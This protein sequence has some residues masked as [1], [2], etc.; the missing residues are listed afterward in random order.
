M[1]IPA[2]IL[3]ALLAG[4]I[5]IAINILLL[6]LCDAAGIVTARGGLQR[7][8]RMWMG[9]PLTQIGVADLWAAAG[10]PGP[11]TALFRNGFK[12][13]VGL[14]MAVFYALVFEPLVARL[15]TLMKGL[16]YALFAWVINAVVVLPLLDEG[17]AGARLLTALGMICF[18][19]AHT[20]FYLALAYIYAWLGAGAARRQAPA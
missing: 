11:D 17:I 2:K 18:A 15:S 8:V 7:L 14:A 16:A 5:A 1:S 13:S 6:N 20:A 10:L 4:V 12:I 3:H 9:G 19:L